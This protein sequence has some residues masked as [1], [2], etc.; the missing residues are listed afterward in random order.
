[1]NQSINIRPLALKSKDERGSVHHFL[2]E[3]SGEFMLFYRYRGAVGA[4]HY[5]KGLSRN[6]NPE[7]FILLQGK[8]TLNWKDLQSNA[9]GSIAL[10]SPVEVEIYPWIW[11]EVIADTDFL[12]LEMNATNEGPIDTFYLENETSK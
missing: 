4:R 8:A 7:Q 9:T 6:K 2:T 3:R 5:H 1:M 10:Q 12:M 11:H